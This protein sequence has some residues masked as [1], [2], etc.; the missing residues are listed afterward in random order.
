MFGFTKKVNVDVVNATLPLGYSK[1]YLCGTWPCDSR[2]TATSSLADSFRSIFCQWPRRMYQENYFRCLS[3]QHKNDTILILA[4]IC[5]WAGVWIVPPPPRST[6]LRRKKTK[7]SGRWLTRW[8]PGRCEEAPLLTPISLLFLKLHCPCASI[9][10]FPFL[11]RSNLCS[12]PDQN[13]P[14]CRS[15]RT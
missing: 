8:S 7:E 11:N 2:S 1:N 5:F 12:T 9:P 6:P 4:N 13:A 3:A 10:K 15:T 14:Q